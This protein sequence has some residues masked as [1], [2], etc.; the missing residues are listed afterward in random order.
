VG[1]IFCRA[2]A[3]L[4]GNKRG[5]YHEKRPELPLWPRDEGAKDIEPA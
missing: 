2:W 3:I 4:P 1:H 5:K